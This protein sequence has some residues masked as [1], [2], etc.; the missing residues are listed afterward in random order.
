MLGVYEDDEKR[1]IGASPIKRGTDQDVRE[2]NSE[3]PDCKN[4]CVAM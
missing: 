1:G 2:E 4:R 3:L